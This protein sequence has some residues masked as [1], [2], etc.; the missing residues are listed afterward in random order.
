MSGGTSNLPMQLLNDFSLVIDRKY[1][2]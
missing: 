2:S 1:Q